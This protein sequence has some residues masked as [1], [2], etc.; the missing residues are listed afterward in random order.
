MFI[1]VHRL[2]IV[3]DDQY[4]VGILSISDLMK[5]LVS[6]FQSK[7]IDIVLFYFF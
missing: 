3:D 7:F 2:I 4:I 1:Q 6:T 5:F